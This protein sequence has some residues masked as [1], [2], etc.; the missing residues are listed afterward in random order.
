MFYHLNRPAMSFQTERQHL[1]YVPSILKF[2]DKTLNCMSSH[3][4][5]TLKL[6]TIS[7]ES[8]IR[9]NKEEFILYICTVQQLKGCFAVIRCVKAW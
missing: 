2:Y 6:Y 8:N 5:R 9:S 7:L 1:M 4:N 3:E